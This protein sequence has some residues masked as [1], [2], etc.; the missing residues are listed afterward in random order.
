MKL[1]V[2]QYVG[3]WLWVFALLYH[4]EMCDILLSNQSV[5]KLFEMKVAVSSRKKET[6]W[7]N[8]RK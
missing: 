1:C 8:K 4:L 6:G 5:F 3:A 7:E 2:D